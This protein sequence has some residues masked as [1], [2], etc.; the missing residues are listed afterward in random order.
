MAKQKNEATAS[1]T[2]NSLTADLKDNSI[3]P[4]VHYG[5]FCGV[6]VTCGE[7]EEFEKEHLRDL[8]GRNP[9]AAINK[10]LDSIHE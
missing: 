1:E 9:K 10:I 7:L 6:V 5:T 8:V 3:T 4:I 2:K